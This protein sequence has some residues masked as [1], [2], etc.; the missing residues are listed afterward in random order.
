MDATAILFLEFPDVQLHY[1]PMFDSLYV[2]GS[3]HFYLYFFSHRDFSV[4]FF[5][6]AFDPSIPYFA[7]SLY[8]AHPAPPPPTPAAPATLITSPPASPAQVVP[9]L[10]SGSD[11]D[12]SE[13][14]D[15]PSS[16][17]TRDADYTLAEPGMAN[18]FLTE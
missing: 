3:Y 8:M 9:N 11:S 2:I 5:H 4:L 17:S 7:I 16:S 18:G 1:D 15:S 6:L 13:A 12:P 14:I 10:S